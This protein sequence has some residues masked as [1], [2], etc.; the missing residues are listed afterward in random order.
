MA[1]QVAEKLREAIGNLVFDE[2]GSITCSFGVTQ[3]AAGETA[4]Q[5]IARADGALY[6]AKA[7]GRNRTKLAPQPGLGTRVL[8]SVA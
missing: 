6:R 8:A 5:F 3:Y 4:A 7:D 1:L 2:V